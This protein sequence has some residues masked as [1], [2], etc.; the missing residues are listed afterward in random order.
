MTARKASVQQTRLE[1][2]RQI[3]EA[4]RS[5]SAICQALED[6]ASRLIIISGLLRDFDEILGARPRP[7]L[8][9]DKRLAWCFA[10]GAR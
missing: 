4:E 6:A 3:L 1:R 5:I 10:R 2:H 8:V 9:F 7:R